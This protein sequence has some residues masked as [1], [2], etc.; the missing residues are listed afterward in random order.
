[1]NTPNEPSKTKPKVSPHKFLPIRGSQYPDGPRDFSKLWNKHYTPPWWDDEDK[2][3]YR[4]GMKVYT[5]VHYSL[6]DPT[7]RSDEMKMIRIYDGGFFLERERSLTNCPPF[8][9]PIELHKLL[10]EAHIAGWVIGEGTA[11][12]SHF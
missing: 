7:G 9:P 2:K 1:M 3:E 12:P 6:K 4:P 10:E 5:M 8:N 11:Y